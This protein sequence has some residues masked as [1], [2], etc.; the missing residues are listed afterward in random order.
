MLLP[1]MYCTR[2]MIA[3]SVNV[4]FC[5]KLL[6]KIWAI[7]WSESLM[8]AKSVPMQNARDT[9]MATCHNVRFKL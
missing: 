4:P 8:A 5:P 2:T 9:L 1:I 6:K 3:H 7:G